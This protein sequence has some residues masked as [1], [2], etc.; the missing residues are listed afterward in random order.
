MQKVASP[1]RSQEPACQYY[2]GRVQKSR[3][4]RF[5]APYGGG[6]F[7]HTSLVIFTFWSR[8]GV[9]RD[10]IW[11]QSMIFIAFER[12]RKNQSRGGFRVAGNDQMVAKIRFPTNVIKP[13]WFW[14][15]W[16][17]KIVALAD[18]SLVFKMFE[19]SWFFAFWVNLFLV[20]LV[21]CLVFKSALFYLR[22]L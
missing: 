2:Q 6:D 16:G 20:I 3:L 19:R 12:R 17:A 18:C 13:V 8:G 15:C 22:F 21:D 7:L 5:L 4:Q 1:V 10:R 9:S 11:V 14:W